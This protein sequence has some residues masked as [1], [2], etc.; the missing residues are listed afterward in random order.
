[1]EHVTALRDAWSSHL[2]SLRDS[3]PRR[4][5][6]Y[7]YASGRREC[8][9]RM[10]LDLISPEDEDPFSD[11]ALERME[12]GN[13]RE[14]A[15]IARLHQ[16][17]PRCMPPFSVVEGQSHFEIKDPKDGV[18]LIRGRLDAR[19]QFDRFTKPV[20]EV[21]SGQTFQNV[22]RLE[23]LDRSPWTKH[24]LDQLLAY[25][26][27]WKEPN[28]I[29]IIDRP[30]LPV[31]LPV[32]LEEHRE[33]AESFLRDA[34]V[35]GDAARGG[36]LPPFIQNAAEC[37]RCPHF[38]KTCS[39]PALD[40]GAGMKVISDPELEEA[41]RIREANRDA[42][43][44]YDKADAALKEALRGVES[45]LL[46]PFAVSGKWQR[47]TKYDVPKEV[48][49]KYRTVDEKGKF[50]LQIDRAIEEPIALPEPAAAIETQ[51][52]RFTSLEEA[53]S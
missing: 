5:R 42:A 18:L 41:A 8:V 32:Y 21:K 44:A 12:R 50:L 3:G 33:R 46:G 1:M 14:H 16:I 25:L 35:A 39:P 24:A 34:R 49:E 23:D 13:E 20:C 37:R 2:R 52:P 29:F 31:F 43:K 15:I 53:A 7:V 40:Y 10:A 19:L 11:D 51:K 45:A 28:G 36:E 26:M 4:P 6:E 30:R 38:G 22:E 17:G 27:A 9:R 47:L 48:K